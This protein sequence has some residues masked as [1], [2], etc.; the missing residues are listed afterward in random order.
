MYRAHINTLSFAAE[1]SAPRRKTFAT[2]IPTGVGY[3]IVL[4]MGFVYYLVVVGC[5]HFLEVTQFLGSNFV[6]TISFDVLPI[7]VFVIVAAVAERECAAVAVA[8]KENAAVA[9]RES[10]AAAAAA[11][12][13]IL[14]G[15]N[16]I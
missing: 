2:T 5:D 8:E 14:L 1:F 13:N 3:S 16:G 15:A 6:N 9:E 7:M 4:P 12:N 10:V 11:A